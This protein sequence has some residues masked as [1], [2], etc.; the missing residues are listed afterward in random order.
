MADLPH[1]GAET[2]FP[3]L[4]GNE[5]TVLQVLASDPTCALDAEEI[6]ERTALT[7]QQV[8]RA[9]GSLMSR[10]PALVDTGPTNV[11]IY[12]WQ[13]VKYSLAAVRV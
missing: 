8:D 10:R 7:L 4:T 5:S 2:T 9:L 13:P 6:A 12:A 11:A 3:P 1:V